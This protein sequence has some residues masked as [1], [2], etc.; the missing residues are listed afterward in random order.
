M[1]AATAFKPVVCQT[2][3]YSPALD[4]AHVGPSN[5]NGRQQTNHKSMSAVMHAAHAN[6]VGTNR[7]PL[8]P[9]MPSPVGR[10]SATAKGVLDQTCYQCHPG[11][12]TQ[13]LRGAMGQAG[14]VCQD[15]HGNM[16][17]VGDDFSRSMP[18]GDFELA[19]DF[20][21]NAKH[22]ARALGQPTGLRLLPYRRRNLQ[23]DRI[24]RRDQGGG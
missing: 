23:P 20:Y 8:F 22:P 2:C 19:P 5:D 13:C 15:C 3:H 12:R 16:A 14:V 24:R 4:L 11:K 21:T 1:R 7:Q 18:G 9:K 17:Q 6:V 10:S